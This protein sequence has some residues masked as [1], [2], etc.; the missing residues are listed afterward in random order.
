MLDSA[1]KAVYFGIASYA[2]W[3]VAKESNFLPPH[4]GGSGS[5]TELFTDYPY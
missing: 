4:L 1:F 2:G 5:L 3:W